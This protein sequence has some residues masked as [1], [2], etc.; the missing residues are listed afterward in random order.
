MAF[1]RLTRPGGSA[2]IINTDHIVQCAPVPES[3]PLA[4][5]QPTGTRVEFANRTHQDVVELVDEVERRLEL[6]A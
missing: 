1:V 6:H 4:G 5:T 3:G 2:V